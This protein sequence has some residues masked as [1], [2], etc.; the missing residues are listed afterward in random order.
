MKTQTK[1]FK[2][3][4]LELDVICRRIEIEEAATSQD[5]E[6]KTF[7]KSLIKLLSTSNSDLA[8]Q[9]VLAA[10]ELV[11]DDIKPE[12]TDIEELLENIKGFNL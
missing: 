3:V 11:S 12:R 7:S 4:N 5:I 10:L 1:T 6:V 8:N 2:E 9:Y